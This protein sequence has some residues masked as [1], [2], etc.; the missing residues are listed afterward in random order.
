M[1]FRLAGGARLEQIVGQRIVVSEMGIGSR[2]HGGSAGRVFRMGLDGGDEMG[3]LEGIEGGAGGV[4]LVVEVALA[5]SLSLGGMLGHAVV[6]S[7]EG[8][9]E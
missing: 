7:G 4:V 6:D 3:E 9:V 5:G 8:G 2:L 1:P